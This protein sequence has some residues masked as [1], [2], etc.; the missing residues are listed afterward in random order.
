[1][2]VKIKKHFIMQFYPVHKNNGLNC[3]L[4]L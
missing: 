2:K 3:I 1:M 4:M